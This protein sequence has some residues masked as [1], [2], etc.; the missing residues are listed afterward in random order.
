MMK[1]LLL[2]VM[3]FLGHMTWA[4]PCPD[5]H[6]PPVIDGEDIVA[7]CT[8]DI[9]ED[10]YTD[11]IVVTE[12]SECGLK[13]VEIGNWQMER[14]HCSDDFVKKYT[15]DWYAEDQAGNRSTFRQN[16]T[17]RRPLRSEIEMPGDTLVQCPAA[18][19]DDT[20]LF[21][22][23][24]VNGRRLQDLCGFRVKNVILDTLL[25][26]EPERCLNEVR[27]EW[28]IFDHC[29]RELWKDTQHIVLIDTI[30]PIIA[31]TAL[32]DTVTL[33]MDPETCCAIYS[34]PVADGIDFCAS[35]EDLVYKHR[36]GEDIVGSEVAL[37]GGI[38]EASIIVSDPCHNADTCNYIIEVIDQDKPEVVCTENIEIELNATSQSIS[39]EDLYLVINDCSS[40]E[41]VVYRRM[42]QQPG[43]EA[44]SQNFTCADVNTPVGIS[45]IV[46]DVHG[47]TDTIE[48]CQVN[49]TV[50]QNVV[51]PNMKLSDGGTLDHPDPVFKSHHTQVYF[52]GSELIVES[53]VEFVGLTLRNMA[54]RIIWN[55]NWDVKQ[56]KIREM[57]PD[58]IH[59]G[60]YFV[61]I[62]NQNGTLENKKLTVF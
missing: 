1:T 59:G 18:G 17:V 26:M 11:F 39:V 54:G 2:F 51:C 7:D 53:E 6:T 58:N 45:I 38:H 49:V 25:S 52:A 31:C 3:L 19:F 9:F 21:G 24:S 40:L 12:E 43:T 15:I 20:D 28:T 37:K 32:K 4:D 61:T 41:S 5:D 55:Q 46:R 34:F 23:P 48:T 27:K 13:T 30:R 35:D 14:G 42:D 62:T 10:P 44:A 33:T 47:N 36:I 22:Y 56:S 50:D 60:I 29:L 57:M 16:V 8:V